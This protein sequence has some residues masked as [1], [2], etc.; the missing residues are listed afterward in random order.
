[1]ANLTAADN[2]Y[3]D[4]ALA[5]WSRDCPLRSRQVYYDQVIA[6][7]N[8]T[9]L[10]ALDATLGLC[11]RA[12]LAQKGNLHDV[13]AGALDESLS[14]VVD[15]L[16]AQLALYRVALQRA[17]PLPVTRLGGGVDA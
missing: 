1:M 14:Q 16:R 17:F 15:N 2:L 7:G 5:V 4:Q 11:Y 10:V 8:V 9:G 3:L 13:E 12:L 6:A